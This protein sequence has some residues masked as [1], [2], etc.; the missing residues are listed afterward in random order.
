MRHHRILRQSVKYFKEYFPRN[1]IDTGIRLSS[2]IP[3]YSSQP[4]NIDAIP[5]T[6][7]RNQMNSWGKMNSVKYGFYGLGYY[8]SHSPGVL[9]KK[10]LRKS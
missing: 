2:V 10:L 4:L 9:K 7:I 3:E 6:N 8:P 5:F 1:T